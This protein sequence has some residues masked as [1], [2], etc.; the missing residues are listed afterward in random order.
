MATKDFF[1]NF[2]INISDYDDLYNQLTIILK[3]DQIK[4]FIIETKFTTH[5]IERYG[6]FKSDRGDFKWLA[7]S[8]YREK[9]DESNRS[10]ID[11]A[12]NFPKYYFLS[13]CFR[14]EFIAWCMR[15]SLTIE[16]ISIPFKYSPNFCIPLFEEI[17]NNHSQKDRRE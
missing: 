7:E 13:Q 12:D 17:K 11:P 2:V 8:S 10:H 4:Y 1:E 6:I 9:S 15:R 16:Q 3:I 14:D 5:H